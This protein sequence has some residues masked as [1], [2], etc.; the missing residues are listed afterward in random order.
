MPR[1]EEGVGLPR[2]VGEQAPYASNGVRPNSVG[3]FGGRHHR[4]GDLQLSDP[5]RNYRHP[6][7][8]EGPEQPLGPGAWIPAFAGM[9]DETDYPP[10]WRFVFR[11]DRGP[12]RAD[13]ICPNSRGAF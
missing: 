4:V 1:L 5:T 3:T 10:I 2:G 8:S 12:P 7:E 11:S 6:R 13:A 9:T